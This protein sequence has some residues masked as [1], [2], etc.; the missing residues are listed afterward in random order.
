MHFFQHSLA[1]LAL[2]TVTCLHLDAASDPLT[3]SETTV[4]DLAIEDFRFTKTR[5][6]GQLTDGRLLLSALPPGAGHHTHAYSALLFDP[7]NNSW[8]WGAKLPKPPGD[9]NAVRMFPL[10]DGRALCMTWKLINNKDVWRVSLYD[11]QT[12]SFSEKTNLTL[13]GS[14]KGYAHAFGA[15]CCIPLSTEELLLAAVSKAYI[16]N[17]TNDTWSAEPDLP[18]GIIVEK[19]ATPLA[20]GKFI[21]KGKE[22]WFQFD[23]QSREW[24]KIGHSSGYAHAPYHPID[25][26]VPTSSELFNYNTGEHSTYQEP[27]PLQPT[28]SPT[29]LRITSQGRDWL[30]LANHVTT[31]RASS[32]YGLWDFVV[33]NPSDGSWYDARQISTSVRAPGNTG[34]QT[35]QA[36]LYLKDGFLIIGLN[37][38][39]GVLKAVRI[40]VDPGQPVPPQVIDDLPANLTITEGKTATFTYHLKG[41]IP[42]GGVKV[43][44]ERVT[45]GDGNAVVVEGAET[46]IMSRSEYTTVRVAAGLDVDGDENTA[47]I[48]VRVIQRDGSMDPNAR[49]VTITMPDQFTQPRGL[50]G[51]VNGDGKVNALDL[52]E[53]MDNFGSSTSD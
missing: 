1:A 45:G 38:E 19:N 32:D 23:I 14:S 21:T 2:S 3:I 37:Y 17:L 50:P 49:L 28:G 7:G 42:T 18:P 16:Y 25:G 36:A 11:P 35:F 44:A 47:T 29:P 34:Q 26:W 40:T 41:T 4:A 48:R 31:D 13:P 51:D 33:R 8:S 5:V 52:A 6:W 12:D 27:I 46:Q 10:P 9:R 24:T 15:Y 39:A 22:D 43:V 30:C 53:V 20:V